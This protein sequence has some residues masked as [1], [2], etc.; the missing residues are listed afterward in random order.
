MPQLDLKYSADLPLNPKA[1]FIAMEAAIQSLD[2]SAG[3]CKSR[4]YPA[5][6]YLHR[7]IYCQ[8]SVLN[9][10]HRDEVFMTLLHKKL[11]ETLTAFIPDE[12]YYAVELTF[13]SNYYATLDNVT[14]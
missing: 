11:L 7:H 5:T 4:A 3:I 6:D 10:P 13:T 8:V 12:C 2:E 14:V 9:K 1:I